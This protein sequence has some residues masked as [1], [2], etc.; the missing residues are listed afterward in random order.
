MA[1]IFEFIKSALTVVGFIFIILLLLGIIVQ[2][3]T[4]RKK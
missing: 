4:D 3:Y 1:E 2:S